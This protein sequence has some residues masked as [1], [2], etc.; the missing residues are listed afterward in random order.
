MYMLHWIGAHCIGIAFGTLCRTAGCYAMYT[1]DWQMISQYI[2]EWRSKYDYRVAMW[3][4]AELKCE[5]KQ[6]LIW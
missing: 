1:G 3:L 2:S 5:F 4:C 6:S